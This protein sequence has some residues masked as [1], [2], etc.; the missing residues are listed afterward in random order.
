MIQVIVFSVFSVVAFI[1]VNNSSSPEEEFF[2][3]FKTSSQIVTALLAV[4]IYINAPYK[5]KEYV[6]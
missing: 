1:D 2:Y 4:Y 5:K 6:G 3:F